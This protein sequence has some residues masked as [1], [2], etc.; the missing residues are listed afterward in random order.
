MVEF[1]A[2]F[3]LAAE[4]F[5]LGK[6]VEIVEKAATLRVARRQPVIR[7]LAAVRRQLDAGDLA[8]AE[9]A[10]EVVEVVRKHGLRPPKVVEVTEAGREP[11]EAEDIEVV[12]YSVVLP[13][14]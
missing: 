12:C 4:E 8:E 10:H 2:C 14:E 7:A 11:I 3:D 13:M 1:A 5:G 9:A 6:A